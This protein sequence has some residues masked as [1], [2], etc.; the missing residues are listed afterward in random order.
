MSRA[1]DLSKL[2]NPNVIKADTTS[3]GF[4]TQI[5][6]NPAN[7]ASSLISAGIV[8][9][10]QFFGDGSNLEG[11]AS[12]GLGT[13]IDDTKDS[14]GQNIYYTN[15]EL[16]IYENTTINAPSTSDVAYTQYAQ[17]TVESG[18]ELIVA[19]GDEFVPDVLGI[20]TGLQATTA[21]AGNGL[22]GTLYADNIENAAGRG[23][24]NFPLGIT[25]SGVSTF[26][27]NVSIG[28]TLTYEDV[29]NVDS[30]GVVTARSGV[31]INA[32][33]LDVTAGGV[34]VTAGGIDAVGIITASTG[35]NAAS[36][37]ILNTGGSERLRIGSAGQIGLA[38]AN[39]G[40]DGQ[41][42]T[43]KGN[44]AAPQWVDAAGTTTKIASG[45]VTS[46]TNTISLGENVLSST[47]MYYLVKFRVHGANILPMIQV[48]SGGAWK[49]D[50]TYMWQQ[51]YAMGGS[52]AQSNGSNQA[53]FKLLPGASGASRNLV[54]GEIQFCNMH[55]T[56]YE[57]PF[58][59][60][61]MYV[62]PTNLGA[63]KCIGQSAGGWGGGNG[64]ITGL[65]ILDNN[66]VNFT[67]GSWVLYGYN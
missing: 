43:S 18:K 42:L 44:A 67:A 38:G 48:Y 11:V 2:G 30:I 41:V 14:I 58:M 6:A 49:A 29:T 40:T 9:A 5:A 52:M 28:G 56:T 33:G 10:A 36:N 62:D 17:I 12:A 16:S 23:G 31:D 21:G 20:G 55:D 53:G 66:S 61:V 54:Q 57:K 64:A 19:D 15:Q 45:T 46:A 1:R 13:A 26:T 7:A 25:V 22:F 37:L 35:F 59:A 24:P 51:Y 32:G 4:G 27:G 50:G 65:R 47:Y 63:D 39:Y 60:Q 3:V 34:K 8:T